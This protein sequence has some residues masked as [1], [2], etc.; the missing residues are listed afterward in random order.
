M[1]TILIAF[2]PDLIPDQ[3]Y[4][5]IE[6]LSDNAELVI[7]E[8]E[9]QMEAALAD[10]EIAAG[11]L[12]RKYLAQMPQLRWF[13]QYG[14]GVDWLMRHPEA[15]DLPFTL[16]N[17]S[18]VHGIQI[19]EHILA[20]LLAFARRLP[21]AWRAQQQ[22]TWQAPAGE[23]LFELAGKTIVVVG[24]GPIGKR[25]AQLCTALGMSVLGVRRSAAKS[26]AG[27]GKMVGPE[28]LLALLPQADFVVL[29]APLTPQTQGMIG[30][31]AL[32][33][34]KP[35]AYLINIGRGGLVDESALIRALQA[36]RL[37]GAGLDVFETEPLPPESPLWAMKNVIITAHYAG[38]SPHY[39]ERWLTIFLENLRRYRRGET[40]ITVVE[41]RQFG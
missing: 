29:T 39:T 28:Q 23:T 34:M 1:P 6:A 31:A 40:L 19:G 5:R 27:V 13:Q 14:A 11:W 17:A 25:T 32:R 18:G 7:T 33:V 8:D 9:A 3:L 26:E 24:M 37:A 22:C 16:T 30:E 2:Q 4:S 38:A 10:V 36:G 41:K 35:A 20:L 12:P 21:E 15:I